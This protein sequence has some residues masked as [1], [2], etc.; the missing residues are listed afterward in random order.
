VV[1]QLGPRVLLVEDDVM[2]AMAMEFFL[3]KRAGT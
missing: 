1:R 3:N 2:I